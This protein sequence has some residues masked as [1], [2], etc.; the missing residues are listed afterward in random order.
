MTIG[1]T[2]KEDID[3]VSQRRSI[4][5]S[6]PFHS[7]NAQTSLEYK[8]LFKEP[9]STIKP[10]KHCSLCGCP[11]TKKTASLDES[12]AIKNHTKTKHLQAK[13]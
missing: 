2:K 13:W 9:Y 10:F 1:L 7:D 4:C 5:Q 12:C 8:N 3:I 11:I 6:C